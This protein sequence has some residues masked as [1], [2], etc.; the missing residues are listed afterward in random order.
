MSTETRV[1]FN[2]I[3]NDGSSS[4]IDPINT[5]NSVNIKSENPILTNNQTLTDIL[6][7]LRSGAFSDSAGGG[8]GGSTPD[9]YQNASETSDGLMSSEDFIKLK[10]IEDGAEK[11]TVTG[12][13][14]SANTDY[15]TGDISIGK[16]DIGLDKVENTSDSEKSVLSASKLST[17]VNINLNGGITA[18][19]SFDGS[20]DVNLNINAINVNYLSGVIN[21]SNL[22]SD[23]GGSGSSGDY[24]ERLII[25]ET[26]EERFNLSDENVRDGD[27]VKVR[28]TGNV[29]RVMDSSMLS[30]EGSYEIY[31]TNWDSIVGKP[32]SIEIP[33]TALDAGI[34]STEQP[35]TACLWFHEV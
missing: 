32:D 3:S 17:P 4:V 23:I 34:V 26:D 5:S 22:P 18:S 7:R 35:E 29:Y 20:K 31:S 6:N 10:N 25:V 2:L 9:W 30:D 15:K 13:K 11:N 28:S 19:T 33:T 21:K 24:I 16:E 27:I 1:K 8:D 14:G 12:V